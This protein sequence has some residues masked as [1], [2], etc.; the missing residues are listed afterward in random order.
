MKGPRIEEKPNFVDPNILNF[1]DPNI[2]N[3][4]NILNH[5]KGPSIEGN[6]VDP[7]ILHGSD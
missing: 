5:C 1:V 3:I 2:L 4:L 7:N 6:F